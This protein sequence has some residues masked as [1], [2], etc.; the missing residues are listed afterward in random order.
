M[1]AT[2][3]LQ[4]ELAENHRRL[5]D[6]FV[7]LE[8]KSAA[9]ARFSRRVALLR[10]SAIAV[11]LLAVVGV[12][13]WTFLGAREPAGLDAAAAVPGGVAT[14]TGPSHAER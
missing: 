13:G 4:A 5:Q 1:T 9:E 6:A 10:I 14:M 3:R 7:E 12:A 11:V 2:E 8:R